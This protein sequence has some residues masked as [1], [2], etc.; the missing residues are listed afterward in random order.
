[1][2]VVPYR[3]AVQM[4]SAALHAAAGGALVL[5]PTGR[6]ADRYRHTARLL[7]LRESGSG[8]ASWQPAA[9]MEFRAWIRASFDLLWDSRRPAGTGARLK[10]WYDAVQRAA[11]DGGASAPEGFLLGPSLYNRMQEAFDAHREHRLSPEDAGDGAVPAWR[12]E[13]FHQYERLLKSNGFL[14]WHEV[15]EAVRDGIRGG[16]IA[17]TPRLVVPLAEDPAPLYGELLDEI[18]RRSS[19]ETLVFETPGGRSIPC[20]LVATAE[21]ECRL[22]VAEAT[23]CWQESRG[24]ASLAMVPLDTE[25]VPILSRCL[26]EMAGRKTAG[27]GESLYS[28]PSDAPLTAHP[29]YLAAVLPLSPPE[30]GIAMALGGW[31]RSTFAQPERFQGFES[32]VLQKLSH[33]D[34]APSW[35]EAVRL[36][37]RRFPTLAPLSRLAQGGS[38]PL[39]GWTGDLRG[40]WEALGF[41]RFD[42]R[43]EVRD[44]CASAEEILRTALDDLDSHCGDVPVDRESALAWI[45][46][47]VEGLKATT[48][49]GGGGIQVLGKG[50]FFGLPFDRV[51]VVGAHGRAIPPASSPQ[52]LLFPTERLAILGGDA[53]SRSWDDGLRLLDGIVACAGAPSDATFSRSIMGPDG[54][55]PTLPC[56]YL[57]D[58]YLV[59]EGQ[60]PYQVDLWGVD[61]GDWMAAPWLAGASAGLANPRDP[62]PFAPEATGVALPADLRATALDDLLQCPFRYFG[63]HILRLEPTDEPAGLSAAQHG[64]LVHRILDGLAR[65][66]NSP[67]AIPGWPQEVGGAWEKLKRLAADALDEFADC[68]PAR[69]E[70]A[71]LLGDDEIGARSLLKPWLEAE[72]RRAQDGWRI[73]PPAPD[74]EHPFGGLRLEAACL[75]VHGKADRVD[76]R[77]DT[78][79]VW[80]YKTGIPPGK[81]AVLDDVNQGQLPA[82]VAALR[83][84]LLTPNVDGTPTPHDGPVQAGYIAVRAMTGSIRTFHLPVEPVDESWETFL[85]RWEA[86]LAGRAGPARDGLYAAD[87]VRPARVLGESK[88]AC[89]NCSFACLC[90]YFDAPRTASTPEEDAQ[91]ELE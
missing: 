30:S 74:G 86:R 76:L 57:E 31:L 84:G 6:L 56:P 48:R 25:L 78:L 61:R 19:L 38:R 39:A 42:G 64:S 29:L 24:R 59:S 53:A 49:R 68:P 50:E 22:A 71:V 34:F 72:Q 5:T 9:A 45:E 60:V 79:A 18:G 54:K 88:S 77:G 75:T 28:V 2:E 82:Y 58:R 47:A 73:L 51:W 15:V 11:K 21:Q 13:V 26:E 23:R 55:Q 67:A 43:P 10:L 36:A 89:A 27:E 85:G 44:A 32:E 69:A 14:A 62:E 7:R 66:L 87:P 12:A 33:S 46:A 83:A 80:D 35:V 52:P 81:Q 16:K 20:R 3:T 41:F 37:G 40:C 8:P 63:R 90:G 65:A 91:E 70:R 4:E 1:M 17:V